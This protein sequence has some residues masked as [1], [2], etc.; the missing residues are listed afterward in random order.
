MK[1]AGIAGA[2]V[3]LALTLASCGGRDETALERQVRTYL[4][5]NQRY[6]LILGVPDDARLG[7]LMCG[8]PGTLAVIACEI[9]IRGAG[10]ERYIVERGPGPAFAFRRCPVGTNGFGEIDLCSAPIKE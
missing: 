3:M 10:A 9:T 1:H 5:S 6:H 7:P 2:L 8:Q 4:E